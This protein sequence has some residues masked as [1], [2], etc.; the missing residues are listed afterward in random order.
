LKER[1]LFL[2]VFIFAF[3]ARELAPTH[4]EEVFSMYDAFIIL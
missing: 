3:V 2:D 1:A 4:S